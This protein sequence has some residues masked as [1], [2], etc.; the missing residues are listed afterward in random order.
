[1]W[2]PLKALILKDLKCSIREMEFLMYL[3]LPLI[4]AGVLK[5][6]SGAIDNAQPSSKQVVVV[7]PESEQTIVQA[8]SAHPRLEVS[9]AQ[10]WAEAQARVRDGE[11]ISAID[12][13]EGLS[14]SLGQDPPPKVQLFHAAG[15]QTAV[16]TVTQSVKRVLDQKAHPQPVVEL[17]STS[18]DGEAK[19][20]SVSALFLETTLVLALLFGGLFVVP[21]GWSGERENGQVEA[22]MLAGIPASMLLSSRVIFGGLLTAS[23]GVGVVLI[24]YGF[25]ALLPALPHLVLGA[26]ALVA[27]GLAVSS[28][29]KTRK[30]AEMILAGV[31]AAISIPTLASEASP[32]LASVGQWLPMGPFVKG[33][34]AAATGM[35]QPSGDWIIEVVVLVGY[36]LLGLTVAAWRVR[37]SEAA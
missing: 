22:L 37:Q 30:Q 20:F 14:A 10:D 34:K 26:M 8:L 2:G 11:V 19:P 4:G 9:A 13:P 1:M 36:T 29:T 27:V 16:I 5:L 31:M 35:G 6:A 33:L 28:L 21:L 12:L 23:S 3:L 25:G 17:V 15:S 24:M 32:A 18:V 7:A